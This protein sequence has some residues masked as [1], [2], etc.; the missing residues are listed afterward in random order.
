MK[1]LLLNPD[2]SKKVVYHQNYRIIDHHEKKIIDIISDKIHNNVDLSYRY[3]EAK[4]EWEYCKATHDR[5]I[6]VV[7]GGVELV[8]KKDSWE[9]HPS[10]DMSSSSSS[11]R[12]E[13]L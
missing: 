11:R 1:I 4:I 5:E 12:K 13:V 10:A 8:G 7:Y 9:G 2:G 3:K 6:K